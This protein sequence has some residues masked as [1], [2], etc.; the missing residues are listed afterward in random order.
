[1]AYFKS[2]G[3]LAASRQ[4]GLNQT[5]VFSVN[6]SGQLTVDW[7][8]NAG[9][10][11]GPGQLGPANFAPAGC[12]LAACQQF[13]LSQTDVFVVGNN[14]QLNVFWVD[15]AGAW[16]GPGGIGAANNAPAGA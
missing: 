15:N 6:E 4:F 14:G 13:G 3:N 9:Y 5:D 10:W 12:P 16:N 8:D 2:G 11:T 1:M 7:V